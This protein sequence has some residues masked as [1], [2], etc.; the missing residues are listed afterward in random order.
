MLDNQ[1]CRDTGPDAAQI[2]PGAAPLDSVTACMKDVDD[3]DWGD[4]SPPPGVTAGSDCDDGNPAVPP[5]C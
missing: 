3:D 1:D 5:G 2:Y 4:E